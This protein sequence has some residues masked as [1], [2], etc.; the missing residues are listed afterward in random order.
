MTRGIEGR[1][2]AVYEFVT[3]HYHEHGVPPT[4]REIADGIDAPT[5]TIWHH[6]Q[7]LTRE[8]RLRRVRR[9]YLPVTTTP[10]SVGHRRPVSSCP[11]GETAHDYAESLQMPVLFCRKCG[12]TLPLDRPPLGLAAS[13]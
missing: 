11:W 6:L 2:E 4:A 3:R 1:R 12:E 5:A 9:K 7:T 13:A 8:G 10:E